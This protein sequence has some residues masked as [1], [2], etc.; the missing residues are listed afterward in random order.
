[1]NILTISLD[2]PPPSRR[3]LRIFEIS[4]KLSEKGHEVHLLSPSYSRPTKTWKY[5]NLFVHE[6][7]SLGLPLRRLTEWIERVNFII[8][9]IFVARN[10]IKNYDIKVIHG[11]NLYCNLIGYFSSKLTN[12]PLFI[13]MTDFF[14]V[15]AKTVNVP[16]PSFLFPI[17]QD[18][19]MKKIPSHAKKVFVVSELMKKK[20]VEFGVNEKNVR[21]YPDGVEIERFDPDISGEKIR[22]KYN[23]GD[24]FT[25]IFH[26]GIEYHDGF[27]IL[28]KS[29]TKLLQRHQNIKILVVGGGREYFEKMKTL[30]RELKIDDSIIFTGWCKFEEV[31]EYISAS[32]V[33]VLPLRSTLTTECITTFKLL[34]YLSMSKPVIATNLSTISTLIKKGKCGIIVEQDD[35]ESLYAGLEYAYSLDKSSLEKMGENGRK[36]IE[37][38]YKWDDIIE[39]EIQ[40]YNELSSDS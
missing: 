5:E 10:I 1:M 20:L 4:K 38:E 30:S 21:V 15:S 28:L 33:G 40:H 29:A 11:W 22:E 2:P 32:N 13:D 3:N 9:G 36:L 27:D 26:G 7:G 34:E 6:V 31:P 35:V 14:T 39:Q 18:L 8:R 24:N 25:F 23:L 37:R 19:E 17:L 12:T 16:L